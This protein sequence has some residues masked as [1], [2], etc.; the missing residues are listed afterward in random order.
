MSKNFSHS[1]HYIFLPLDGMNA[2]E[3]SATFGVPRSTIGDKISGRSE[4][5]V[6]SRGKSQFIPLEIEESLDTQY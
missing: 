4:P 2:H 5:K 1:L 6:S 3:A